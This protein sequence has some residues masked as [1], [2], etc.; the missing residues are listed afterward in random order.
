MLG[1]LDD[2]DDALQET[3]VRVWRQINSFEPRAPFRA[4]L[5]RIAT[6]VCL[7]MLARRT[8]RAEVAL[9][10]D[11][12]RLS[13]KGDEAVPLDPYPDHWLEEPAA[14]SLDS[15][16]RIEQRESVE[17]A[18]VA[19]VQLLPPLQR[20]SLLLR[21][22]IGYTAAEVAA[23]LST[24]IAGVNSALQRARASLKQ[25]RSEGTVARV[26]SG[27]GGAVEQV[28]VQQLINAWHASDVTAIVALLTE[29]ALLTMPP[30]PMRFVG[31]DAIEA[32]L[33][34]QPGGGRL[35][36]FRLVSTRA[37]GQPALAAYEW[38][39]QEFHAHALIVLAI[40]GDEIASLTRFAEPELFGRF[41]LPI[42]FIG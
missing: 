9:E 24:S 10:D 36:Q 40:Q 14:T 32:F 3:F 11:G 37:N 13:P 34:T 5:Y 4:W 12:I 35:D 27:S 16:A 31:R 6:N 8:R 28:L 7:T 22:V 23:M 1:S 15:E 42:T 20:A 25:A 38:D 19:A 30:E 26:H 41:G 33:R 39:G 2:A 21:D 29:D 18:F 17:L